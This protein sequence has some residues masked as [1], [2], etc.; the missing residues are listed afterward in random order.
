M[1]ATGR[2]PGAADIVADPAETRNGRTG[3]RPTTVVVV[4]QDRD[5]IGLVVTDLDGTLWL[6]DGTVVSSRPGRQ[7]EKLERSESRFSPQ[8]PADHGRRRTSSRRAE[9][10]LPVVLLNGALGRDKGVS[11]RFTSAPSAR[12]TRWTSSTSSNDMG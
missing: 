2:R 5:M 9:L 4:M 7:S 10:D 3:T 8:P 11:P 1:H 12:S 6:G